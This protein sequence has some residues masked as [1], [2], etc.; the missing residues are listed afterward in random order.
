MN[1]DVALAARA[2]SAAADTLL[3]LRAAGDLTGRALGDAGD[4]AAQ[5]VIADLLTAER[6]AD[7]VFSEEAVDDRRRLTADR[8]WIVDPLDG[9]REYGEPDRHDWAV[10]V[11]LWSGGALTA[12][13]VALPAL[14]SVLTTW[15]PSDVPLPVP[16]PLRI[17]VSRT[18]RPAEAERVAAA[19]GG[20]LVPLGSA[21][22]KTMA[23][24]LGEAD[25][26]VHAGGMYQW[27]SAAP[28][29]VAAA[30]GLHTSRLDGSPLVY[31]AADAWLPDLVV[32][33]AERAPEVLAAIAATP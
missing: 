7:V 8:V 27:D 16:G 21:G 22:Y 30:A 9:T 5:Q 28:V 23:L 11:A 25:A 1:D 12:A 2:A 19:V 18:R 29:A 10:H 24:L 14:G 26:Y 3:G 17:A 31:N 13:A 20:T 15:P 6:P 33:R 32:C 4:A